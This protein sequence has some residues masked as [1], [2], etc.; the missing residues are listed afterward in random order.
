MTKKILYF[1]SSDTL[2]SQIVEELKSLNIDIEH[3]K[4]DFSVLSTLVQQSSRISAIV[5][6]L[7]SKYD[8]FDVI[9]KINDKEEF[10]SIPIIILSRFPEKD[11]IIKALQCGA[12][13]YIIQPFEK[14]IFLKKL[15]D[16][17]KVQ[18]IE[19][20]YSTL[21]ENDT[22]TFDFMSM[23]KKELK[24]AQRGK[25]PVSVMLISLINNDGSH[26]SLFLKTEILNLFKKIINIKLRDTDTI[27][28]YRDNRLAVILPF[29][30]SEG[31]RKVTSNLNV[32]FK[33]SSTVN[34]K[35][36]TL[37]LVLTHVSFPAHTKGLN[38]L[39]I[40]LEHNYNYT[41]RA[42]LANQTEKVE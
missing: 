19:R 38:D 4:N 36:D 17:L 33:N 14:N 2:D 23:L 35:S 26:P 21:D 28:N 18:Y 29:A 5:W 10:K 12:I 40:M 16:I 11:C 31:A 42:R 41:L 30:D 1:D 3:A 34:S 37:E 20:T 6:S 13:E 27:F 15:C 8:D 9:K 25:Y 32:F 39:I 24:S 7:R 22:I